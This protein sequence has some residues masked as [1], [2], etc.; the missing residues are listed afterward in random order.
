[1]DLTT[2]A[3]GDVDAGPGFA[4][5]GSLQLQFA[6]DAGDEILLPEELADVPQLLD[7]IIVHRHESLLGHA[8]R[9]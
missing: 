5:G 3:D 2:I 7:R 1:L 6:A 8:A 4:S 9:P